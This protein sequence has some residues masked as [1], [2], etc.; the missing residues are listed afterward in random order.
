MGKHL[1]CITTSLLGVDV[2]FATNVAILTR[3]NSRVIGLLD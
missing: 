3:P 2:D 1:C